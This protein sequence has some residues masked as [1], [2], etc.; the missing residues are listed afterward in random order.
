MPNGKAN[1]WDISTSIIANV[2][3][4]HPKTGLAVVN[5][6]ADKG[7][8]VYFQQEDRTTSILRYDPHTPW[9]FLWNI[10]Q[11]PIKGN[12]ISAG[13]TDQNKVTVVTPRD[14]GNIEVSTLQSNETWVIC[15]LFRNAPA[16]IGLT[17]ACQRRFQ[18]L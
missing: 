5:L 8:Q 13:F 18:S 16:E 4:I 15:E 7:Y 11:D 14:E 9:G 10:S 12:P 6:G 1:Q 2:A 17:L 3:T